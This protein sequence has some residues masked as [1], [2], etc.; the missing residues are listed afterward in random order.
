VRA[1]PA[2]PIETRSGDPAFVLDPSRGRRPELDG[3]RGIAALMVL[4]S[5]CL[6]AVAAPGAMQGELLK[7]LPGAIGN[8]NS[9][10]V[11]FFVLSGVVLTESL[12]RGGASRGGVAAF[13]VRRACRLWPAYVV[14]LLFAWMVTGWTSAAAMGDG[15][16]PWLCGVSRVHLAVP[17][18]LAS[19]L[20]PG[21]AF[22]QLPHGWTLTIELLMSLLLPVMLLVARRRGIGIVAGVAALGLF[23]GDWK[24]WQFSIAFVAGVALALH[25]DAVA[26]RVAALSP[27]AMALL[28]AASVTAF[29]LPAY[30]LWPRTLAIGMGVSTAGAIGVLLLAPRIRLLARLL[31]SAPL[32]RLG[33][34]SYSVYLLH[35]PVLFA[36]A[37]LVLGDDAATSAAAVVQRWI[38]V[39]AVATAITI[40]LSAAVWKC[41]EAPG[42]AAGRKF[43]VRPRISHV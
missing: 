33:V 1:V 4:L 14:A 43:G 22:H 23:V 25:R 11:L 39:S 12:E 18:L 13:Y 42:I 2:L 32:E 38:L 5:H 16:S 41:I 36:V 15:A 17:Q 30:H 24:A 3:L 28:L 31:R 26:R 7:G 34:L 21:T 9:A 6:Q 37:P 19:L 8:G 35:L 20:M 40:P 27:L 29:L 10:V